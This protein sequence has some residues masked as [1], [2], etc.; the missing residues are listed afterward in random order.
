ME[1][2]THVKV[3]SATMAEDRNRL[4]ETVT[5]WLQTR[6]CRVVDYVVR[7]SSDRGFHCVSIIVFYVQ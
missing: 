2:W 4:G 6:R 7:Q 1:E 3:F 5:M